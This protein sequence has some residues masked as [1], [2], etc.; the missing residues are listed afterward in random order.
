[1]PVLNGLARYKTGPRVRAWALATARGL[2]GHDTGEC[3]AGLG[4]TRN[5]AGDSGP[6]QCQSRLPEWTSILLGLE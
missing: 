4:P 3:S 2:A 6:G 5:L 1:V